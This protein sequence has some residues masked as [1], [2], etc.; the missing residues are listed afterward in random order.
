MSGQTTTTTT[1]QDL[2]NTYFQLIHDLRQG[3]PASVDSLMDLWDVDGTFD[4]CGSSPVVASYK[5]ATAIRTLYKNRLNSNG[6]PVT[7]ELIMGGPVEAT[8]GIVDTSVTNLKTNGVRAIAA[9]RTTIGTEEGYGFDVAGSHQ[10]TIANDKITNLRVTISPKPDQSV[11]PNLNYTDLT[12]GDV[13]RLS[14]AAWPV[15]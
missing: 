4:F 1:P 3:D 14:L 9:W 10:F 12:V 13:G 7:L 15:V 6:M 2:V 8:L 11:V 5:G